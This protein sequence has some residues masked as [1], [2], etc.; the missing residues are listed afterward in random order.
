MRDE[1]KR[2]ID[3]IE[4]ERDYCIQKRENKVELRDTIG[5]V[6]WDGRVQGLKYALAVL[7]DQPEEEGK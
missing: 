1:R 6:G 7:R 2:I 5:A 4:R 3:D